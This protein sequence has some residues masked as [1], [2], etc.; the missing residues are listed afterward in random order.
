MST[1]R[2]DTLYAAH[3]AA[4]EKF[5]YFITGATGA[6]AGYIGQALHPT[7]I[8]FNPTTVELASVL[9]LLVSVAFGLKRIENV[10]QIIGVN[11]AALYHEESAGALGAALG[12]GPIF[13]EQTGDVL[14]SAEAAYLAQLHRGT[15]KDLR[16][17][18][19]QLQARGT[20]YYHARNWCLVVGFLLLLTARILP[21][22][23]PSP[24]PA[25]TEEPR[26]R[27]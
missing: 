24:A 17:K 21:A 22:Y 12:P 7:S 6:L 14:S 16:P 9:V 8:G 20:T 1:G 23:M 15:S 13:N 4:S 3:A 18:L 26:G 10:I 19:K 11:H 27:R 5:D 25:T 2:S